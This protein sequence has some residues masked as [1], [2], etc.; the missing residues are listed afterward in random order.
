MTKAGLFTFAL[1]VTAEGLSRQ[2]PKSRRLDK[3]WDAGHG[4]T[5]KE[6]KDGKG[7]DKLGVAAAKSSRSSTRLERKS[8]G[9]NITQFSYFKQ[10]AAIETADGA[11]FDLSELAKDLIEPK[12]LSSFTENRGW[13]ILFKA[14]ED[15]LAVWLHSCPPS[16][17]FRIP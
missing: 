8:V 16:L 9:G 2:R 6:K 1:T 14:L 13:E 12:I 3:G 7:K 15:R 5:S 10:V 17:C 11:I 4:K